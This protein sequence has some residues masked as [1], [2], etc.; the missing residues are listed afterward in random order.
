MFLLATYT[1]VLAF[2]S[3]AIDLLSGAFKASW[4]WMLL[5]AS[6]GPGFLASTP[7]PHNQSN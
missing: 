6:I 7:K 1:L 3:S 5:C 4:T 2:G